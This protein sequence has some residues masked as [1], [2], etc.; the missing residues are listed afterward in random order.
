M[1]ISDKKRLFKDAVE[2]D[3]R[4]GPLSVKENKK[5]SARDLTEKAVVQAYVN[6]SI[7]RLMHGIGAI[8]DSAK[9]KEEVFKYTAQSIKNYLDNPKKCKD[10]FRDWHKNVCKSIINIFNDRGYK[11]GA[12]YKQKG[13]KKEVQ[14]DVSYGLAQKS[15]NMAF[16][17]LYCFSDYDESAFAFCDCPIDSIIAKSILDNYGDSIQGDK[18]KKIIK[19]LSKSQKGGWSG[20]DEAGY[21]IVQGIITDLSKKNKCSNLE[22]DL[23]YWEPRK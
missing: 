18:A 4:G 8:E 11:K 7:F 6:D 23:L 12:Y 10:D 2:N 16:K 22:F 21:E 15:V 14:K 3:K 5:D 20:L 13:V 1:T 19:D 9:L 17:Y